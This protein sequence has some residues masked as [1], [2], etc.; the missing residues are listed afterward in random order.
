MCPFCRALKPPTSQHEV[1]VCL[2]ESG[3][4]EARR[5]KRVAKPN[6]RAYKL[7]SMCSRYLSRR[8]H[9]HD[10]RCYIS[11][12]KWRVWANNHGLGGKGEM[13]RTKLRRKKG[14]EKA[15]LTL[16]AG[17]Q[18]STPNSK[19]NRTDKVDLSHFVILKRTMP[20]LIDKSIPHR[21][22]PIFTQRSSTAHT[23]QISVLT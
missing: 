15:N 5:R 1:H 12:C 6:V 23:A 22:E 21:L 8:I 18:P 17:T 11:F 3:N 13:P 19:A 14:R 16:I 20:V 9:T 4:H 10:W 2:R 7:E